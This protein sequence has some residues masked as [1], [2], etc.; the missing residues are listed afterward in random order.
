MFFFQSFSGSA[1]PIQPLVGRA[2]AEVLEAWQALQ[3]IS[4]LTGRTVLAVARTV[5]EASLATTLTIG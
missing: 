2:A 3:V 4:S 1:S 5:P